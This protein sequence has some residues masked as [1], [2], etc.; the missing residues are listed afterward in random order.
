MLWNLLDKQSPG[1]FP[2]KLLSSVC[3]CLHPTQSWIQGGWINDKSVFGQPFFLS[4][5][6]LSPI[7]CQQSRLLV[8]IERQV[9]VSKW[10]ILM[11]FV[12]LYLHIVQLL[13]AMAS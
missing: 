12:P 5:L 11:I 8:M 7:F 13:G 4:F 1:F 10:M 2:H 3:V 9:K 6:L